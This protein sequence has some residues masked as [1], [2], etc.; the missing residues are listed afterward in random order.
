LW[1]AQVVSQA[2]DWLNRVAVLTLVGT[3]GGNTAVVG[4]GTLFGAELAFRLLPSALLGPIAGPV[5]D[6]LPRR[7]LMVTADVLRAL[8]VAS[9]CFVRARRLHGCTR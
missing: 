7:L 8:V 5:A 2:G 3:L 4:V 1:T 6:R 9:M